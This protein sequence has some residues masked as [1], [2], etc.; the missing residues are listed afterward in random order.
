ML[1]SGCVD[2]KIRKSS[3][4]KKGVGQESN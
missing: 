3:L 2:I 4:E 1:S